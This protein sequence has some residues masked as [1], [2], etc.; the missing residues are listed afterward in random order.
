[1]S[2][3][4]SEVEIINETPSATAIVA[5]LKVVSALQ[6]Q[7][8]PSLVFSEDP[9]KPSCSSNNRPA[10]F[11]CCRYRR[12]SDRNFVQTISDASAMNSTEAVQIPTDFFD[13]M[14]KPRNY[15]NNEIVWAKINTGAQY[16]P[17]VILDPE[18][19]NGFKQ[20][21]SSETWVFWLGY[22]K[23]CFSKAKLK[24]IAKFNENFRAF[25]TPQS[26]NNKY[27]KG[28]QYALSFILG[29]E[30][31]LEEM[32]QMNIL[33]KPC[34]LAEEDLDWKVFTPPNLFREIFSSEND[35]PTKKFPVKRVGAKKPKMGRGCKTNQITNSL[36][37]PINFSSFKRPPK[38]SVSSDQSS[39][40]SRSSADHSIS[41]SESVKKR[42]RIGS[43]MKLTRFPI[44]NKQRDCK[45]AKTE[46]AIPASFS[47]TKQIVGQ[48][49]VEHNGEEVT[50]YEF[51]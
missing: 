6:R 10:V 42:I 29:E 24:Y 12:A 23:N 32:N 4:D 43:A 17:A 18:E 47:S 1:M 2:G 50:F 3:S 36:N 41:P 40:S 26:R 37:A 38:R 30:V 27:L 45:Q 49:C 21:D 14:A 22:E 39:I 51:E 15:G 13:R 46:T 25:F 44:E 11:C 8:T 33:H 16:W 48:I 7:S 5:D 31:A 35:S 34:Y 28:V 20:V 19:W 9:E